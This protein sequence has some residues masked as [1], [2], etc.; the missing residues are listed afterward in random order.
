M[1]ETTT[2]QLMGWGRTAPTVARVLSTPDAETIVEAVT[3][4]DGRG[5]VARGLG[6]SYGDNAQ[7]GGGLVV[8]MTALHQIHS[9]DRD[10]H[11]VDVDGGVKLSA[12]WLIER[13][14][15]PRGYPGEGAPVRLSTK[16]TLAL[17][18]R[19]GATTGQLAELAREV[20]AGVRAA[21]GVTLH[22]E[23]L[24]VGCSIDD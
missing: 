2:K 11:L 19:G 17:T 10:T 13:A 14:G 1:F 7:N 3:S 16:H 24:W 9:M 22:P 12:A 5:I 21:F 6:R 18:N 20:R 8:D 4:A 23:P 15:F